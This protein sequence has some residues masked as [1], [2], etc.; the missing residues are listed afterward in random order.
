MANPTRIPLTRVTAFRHMTVKAPVLKFDLKEESI[1][2]VMHQ[3]KAWMLHSYKMNS[4]LLL[5][6]LSGTK[7]MQ[8]L[9]VPCHSKHQYIHGCTQTTVHM[10]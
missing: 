5:L 4:L 6:D 9:R 10:H 7:T 8:K 1:Q 2:Y 3:R